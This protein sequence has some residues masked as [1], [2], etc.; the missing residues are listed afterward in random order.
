MAVVPFE[1]GKGVNLKDIL[2][3]AKPDWTGDVI[4]RVAAQERFAHLPIYTWGRNQYH[5][6]AVQSRDQFL[7]VLNSFN[8]RSLSQSKSSPE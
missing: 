6:K 5:S 2:C 4:D 7:D 1:N 3:F 8:K